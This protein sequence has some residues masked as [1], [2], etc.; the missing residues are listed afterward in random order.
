[1]LP[2]LHDHHL[3]GYV[4]SEGCLTLETIPSGFNRTPQLT[5]FEGC[6]AYHFPHAE[7]GAVLGHIVSSDLMSFLQ[8]HS[9]EFE[10][11]FTQCGWPSWWRGS[12]EEAYAYLQK[13]GVSALEITSAVGF[14]GW[15]LAA[16]V[17]TTGSSNA[18]DHQ[19]G[20]PDAV[21]RRQLP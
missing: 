18:A 21:A 6:E 13:R 15:V 11:G 1:M 9:A 20:Q 10:D 4:V 19:S 7:P 5:I 8:N 12:I 2:S 14:S 16:T 17:T 3:L